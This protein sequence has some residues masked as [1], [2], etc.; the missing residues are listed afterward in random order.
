M[1]DFGVDVGYVRTLA[2]TNSSYCFVALDDTGEK[3]LTIVRTP[4]F[5][6]S[7]DCIDFTAVRKARAVHIAPFDMCIAYRI[8]DAATRDAAA[9][10]VDLEPGMLA[11]GAECLEDLLRLTTIAFPNEMFLEALFPDLSPAKAAKELLGRGPDVVVATLGRRGAVVV[12]HDSVIEVPAVQTSV[13]D[14]TGAGDSF[15]A[16]IVSLWLDGWEVDEAAR[17]AASAA[18]ISIGTLG[19]RSALPT[20]DQ[21]LMLT[22]ARGQEGTHDG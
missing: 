5:F 2:N 16:A 18:S 1:E 6:P 17:V 14:T 22:Q 8:A 7:I 11:Q 4:T 13:V 15:N 9:V 21:A 19:A 20:R 10:T 12:G 3:A